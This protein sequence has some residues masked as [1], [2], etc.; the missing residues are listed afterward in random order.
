MY[1][2]I[3]APQVIFEEARKSLIIMVHSDYAHTQNHVTMMHDDVT[4]QQFKSRKLRY[5]S[6]DRSSNRTE[7]IVLWD[8]SR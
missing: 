3:D 1:G 4:K 6:V 7:Y 5:E 2:R 8:C